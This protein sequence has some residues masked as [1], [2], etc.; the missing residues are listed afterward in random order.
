MAQDQVSR[1]RF[2]ETASGL[3]G[4]GMIA[5]CTDGAAGHLLAPRMRFASANA[6]AGLLV[7]EDY[8]TIQAAVD[9]AADGDTI[10][11]SRGT[12][13][14]SVVIEKSGI[15]LRARGPG[16]VIDADGGVAIRIGY[17]P[18]SAV[19]CPVHV[20]R[21]GVHGFNLVGG[22]LITTAADC[23]VQAN[24][25]Q[26]LARSVLDFRRGVEILF[27]SEDIEISHNTLL[28]ESSTMQQSFGVFSAIENA[29]YGPLRS[30]TDPEDC[31]GNPLVP[32]T[33]PLFPN[34]RVSVH[35]NEIRGFT[36]GVQVANTDGLAIEQNVVQGC[37]IGINLFTGARITVSGN[38]VAACRASGISVRGVVDGVVTGNGVVDNVVAFRL[39]PNIA[40]HIAA[41]WPSSANLTVTHNRFVRSSDMDMDLSAPA[42]TADM[43]F[44]PNVLGTPGKSDP[45]APYPDEHRFGEFLW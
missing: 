43:V 26:V 18:S 16:V 39:G 5:A 33:Q 19:R 20:A 31:S 30:F 17:A 3:V 27:N 11:V 34:R 23:R 41:G 2:L 12:Y 36:V 40:S 15:E 13:S 32:V 9:A 42:V 4:A 28:L 44:A 37:A 25:M 10:W 8:A 24:V 21:I 6:G 38:S 1:R 35:H 7:P 14:E 29:L 22:V 45:R